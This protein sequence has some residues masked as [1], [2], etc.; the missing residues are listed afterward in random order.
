MNQNK[1]KNYMKHAGRQLN[2]L[3]EILHKFYLI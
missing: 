2:V 1:N 3:K